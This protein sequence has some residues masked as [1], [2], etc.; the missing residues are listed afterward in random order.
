VNFT[1]KN[2]AG[3]TFK[4]ALFTTTIMTLAETTAVIIPEE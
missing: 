3:D 4:D 2:F 1:A